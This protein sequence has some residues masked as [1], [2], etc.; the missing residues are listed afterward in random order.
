[1]K[2]L[3]LFASEAFP[4]RC[5]ALALLVKCPW[6][7]VQMF[8]DM[9]NDTSGIAADT[10]SAVHK[11]IAHWHTNERG[12]KG[13]IKAMTD[14]LREYPL[15]DLHDAEL[16]FRLYAEDPRNQEAEIVAVEKKVTFKIPSADLTQKEIY[17]VGTLDQIRRENGRLVLWDVKTGAKE[18][19][20]MIHEH[21]IQLA[22]YCIGATEVLGESVHPGGLIRTR[23]YRKRGVSSVSPDG[24]FWSVPWN[25]S[26]ASILLEPVQEVVSRI[27]KGV[28][29][30]GPGDHCTYCPALGIDNCLP[31]LKRFCA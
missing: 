9:A 20:T 13:A 25:L 17:I 2:D 29:T 12:Y 18:G 26:D 3:S 30:L 6:R 23:G 21:S 5:S 31:L 8:L 15:A 16:H 24:V 4:L 22:A 28:L 10:G 27:R 11:A 14:S 19:F 1:M 7:A